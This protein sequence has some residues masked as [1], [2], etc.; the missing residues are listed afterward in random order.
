MTVKIYLQKYYTC[1]IKCVY[2]VPTIIT[3]LYKYS[4]DDIMIV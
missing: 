1:K 2:Y 3:N 4:H